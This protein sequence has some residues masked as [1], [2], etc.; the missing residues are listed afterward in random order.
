MSVVPATARSEKARESRG[1]ALTRPLGQ[2]GRRA[3]G[4]E[5]DFKFEFEFEFEFRD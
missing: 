1:R 3:Q 4:F 5:F 2:F